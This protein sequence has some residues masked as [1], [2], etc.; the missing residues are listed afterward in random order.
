MSTLASRT[1]LMSAPRTGRHGAAQRTQI[2]REPR[3]ARPAQHV[4]DLRPPAPPK[5]DHRHEANWGPSVDRHHD[6]LAALDPQHEFDN[7]L[8]QFVRHYV[9]VHRAENSVGAISASERRP[10]PVENRR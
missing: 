3:S 7:R 1:D 8:P 4:A 9:C 10:H 5:F 6:A 2:S